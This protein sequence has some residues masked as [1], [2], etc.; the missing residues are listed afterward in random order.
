MGGRG[1]SAGSS[2]GRGNNAS[3]NMGSLPS[4]VEFDKKR[5]PMG[6]SVYTT[7]GR[8]SIYRTFISGG[9]KSR[10]FDNEYVIRDS[11]GRSLTYDSARQSWGTLQ[12]AMTFIENMYKNNGLPSDRYRF[13]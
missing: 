2:G 7:D 8:F 12:A 3:E 1:N 6:G 11:G 9:R 10:S 5:V 4:T 13:I